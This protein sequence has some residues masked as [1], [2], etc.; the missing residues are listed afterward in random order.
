[1][2]YLAQNQILRLVN[3]IAFNNIHKKGNMINQI[4]RDLIKKNQTSFQIYKY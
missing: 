1:M 3:N 2:L 4:I